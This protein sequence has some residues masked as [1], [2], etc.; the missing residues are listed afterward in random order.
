M[1]GACACGAVT[2]TLD[3]ARPSVH[4]CRCEACRA[5]TGS[6]FLSMHAE[7]SEV[8]IDGP[9]R[10][11]RSSEHGERGFC[12]TCGATLFFRMTASDIVSYGMAAGLFPDAADLPLKA[13]YFAN[14]TDGFRIGGSHPRLNEAQTIERSRPRRGGAPR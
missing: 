4:A 2:V 11:Y 9:V 7:A 10:A 6:A 13:E 1:N 12:S 5:W 8:R 14:E 3:V